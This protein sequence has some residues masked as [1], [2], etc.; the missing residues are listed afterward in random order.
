MQIIKNECPSCGAPVEWDSSVCGFCKTGLKFFE[1]ERSVLPINL[2]SADIES[3]ITLSER[4]FWQATVNAIEAPYSMFKKFKHYNIENFK[5][6]FSLPP[7]ADNLKI[8]FETFLILPNENLVAG[9]SLGNLNRYALLT[10]IRLVIFRGTNSVSIPLESFVSW[11]NEKSSSGFTGN[12]VLRFVLGGVEKTITFEGCNTYIAPEII[13]SV[14]SCKEW[15]DLSAF[16]RN[17]ISLSRYKISKTYNIKI[18]TFELMVPTN[19]PTK[20]AIPTNGCFVATATMGD[21]NHPT[22]IELQC[23]RDNYLSKKPWG[24]VLILIYNKIGPEM[25]KVI[26]KSDVLKTLSFVF[27]IKPAAIITRLINH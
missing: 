8:F 12:P 4:E 19:P 18:K 1:D 23:F 11:D 3:K 16:Q 13:Q 5:N 17:I 26:R 21:Y 10:S 22:V 7:T 14:I 20:T 25:A 27:L 6:D 15:E 9:V 2:S 24:S